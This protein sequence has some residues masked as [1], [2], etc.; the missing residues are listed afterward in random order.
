VCLLLQQ[1]KTLNSPAK[2][3]ATEMQSQHAHTAKRYAS[4]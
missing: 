4:L 2:T 3:H 1:K